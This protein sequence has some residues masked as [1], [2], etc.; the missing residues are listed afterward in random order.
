MRK[1]SLVLLVTIGLAVGLSAYHRYG[2][3][4]SSITKRARAVKKDL[5]GTEGCWNDRLFSSGLDFFEKQSADEDVLSPG[6]GSWQFWRP[7]YHFYDP[8]THRGIVP[9]GDAVTR[10]ADL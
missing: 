5:H 10:M 1:E 2:P 9:W 3:G 7:L 8:G 6:S 4:H